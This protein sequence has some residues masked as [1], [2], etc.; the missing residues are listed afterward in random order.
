[1]VFDGVK[2]NEEWAITKTES[3]FI[4]HERHTLPA[5]KLKEVYALIKLKHG[6]SKKP[7]PEIKE[8]RRQP[9]GD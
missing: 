2:F 3:Q 7:L 9:D 5:A 8:D 4:E 1:M 6:N